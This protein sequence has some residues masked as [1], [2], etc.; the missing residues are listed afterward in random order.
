M[1]IIKCPGCGTRI[2]DKAATCNS[3]GFAIGG[4]DAESLARRHAIAYADKLNKLISQQMLAMLIFIA[5]LAGSVLEWEQEGWKQHMPLVSL[6]VSGVAIG[7]Y[8]ITR[9]R[10]FI[11]KRNR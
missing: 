11:L 4:Q 5:G 1:A 3:C 6:V 8:L 9:G 2:S 7:W 10:I